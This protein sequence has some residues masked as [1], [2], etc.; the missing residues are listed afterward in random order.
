MLEALR[1]FPR[2][3]FLREVGCCAGT[4][5][6]LIR[7]AFPWVVLEGTEISIEAATFAQDKFANDAQTRV[8]CT[9]MYMDA[10]L[11]EDREVDVTM[12]CYTLA[13]VPP[14]DLD[15]ILWH[16]LRASSVGVL[17]IEPTHGEIGQLP[18][19]YTTVWRHD[20][21]EAISR[22]MALD[23]RRADLS[24]GFI[25]PSIEDCDGLTMVKFL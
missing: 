10:P 2:F 24:V 23:P 11:W 18:H 13:Y 5:L 22:I 16:M 7:E 19:G 1:A 21:S 12:S 14:D 15:D 3:E 8:V 6:R 9:D 20:Y 4:N 17:I 25:S